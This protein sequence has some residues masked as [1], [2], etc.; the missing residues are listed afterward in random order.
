[1]VVQFGGNKCKCTLVMSAPW[2]LKETVTVRP[3]KQI[4]IPNIVCHGFYALCNLQAGQARPA[5]PSLWP[6]LA[7][8]PSAMEMLH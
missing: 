6:S 5:E 7:V 2:Q 3:K 8:S 1:M 4:L